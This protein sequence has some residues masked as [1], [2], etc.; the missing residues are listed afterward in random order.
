MIKGI[1]PLGRKFIE[2]PWSFQLTSLAITYKG[3]LKVLGAADSGLVI[4]SQ[5]VAEATKLLQVAQDPGA[6]HTLSVVSV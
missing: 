2:I 3:D 4:S 1:V 6:P 5:P